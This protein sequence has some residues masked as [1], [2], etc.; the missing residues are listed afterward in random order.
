MRYNKDMK[1]TPHSELRLRQRG[2]RREWCERA[3]AEP[4]HAEVQESGR[5]RHWVFV[6]ELG[7]WLRVVTEADYETLVTAHFDRRFKGG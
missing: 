4:E 7:K 2:I 5:I 3:I 1:T 6:E